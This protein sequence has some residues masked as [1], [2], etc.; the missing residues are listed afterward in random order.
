MIQ[1][2]D[3]K[4]CQSEKPNGHSFM[5][6]GGV[7]GL[8]RCSNT[9]IVIVIE[10]VKGKDGLKGSM[11]LCDECLAVALKQLPEG[12]FDIINILP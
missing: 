8:V 4:R 12:Y 3:T 9:P 1:P 5:T 10:A 6:L 2:V 7:P 11:S